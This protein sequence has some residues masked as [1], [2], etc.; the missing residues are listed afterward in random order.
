MTLCTSDSANNTLAGCSFCNSLVHEFE[1]NGL[2][3]YCVNVQTT[4]FRLNS[5]K[6]KYLKV[7]HLRD[8]FALEDG[9]FWEPKNTNFDTNFVI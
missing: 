1:N 8:L 9:N 2:T 5:W 3:L 6:T 4:F 7:I